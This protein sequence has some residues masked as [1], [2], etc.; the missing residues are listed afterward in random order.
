MNPKQLTTVGLLAAT[1]ALLAPALAQP[2]PAK[3]PNIVL[4]L[5]DD[6][7]W[8]DTSVA[9]WTQAT[10]LNQRFHTPSMQR[11]AAQGEVFTNAYACAICSPSHVSLMTGWNAARHRVTN[12]T[13]RKGEQTDPQRPN[14]Q[15]APWNVNGL[16][17]SP[18]TPRAAFA[19]TLPEELHGA[20]YRTI[21]VGKAHWGAF[22]TPGADPKNLGF[23]VNIGGSGTGQPGSYFGQ[24]NYS[25]GGTHDVPGLEKYHGTDT[26]LS[27]A[28][29]LKPMR[30]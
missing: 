27:E 7:G 24:K 14:L 17:N 19:P 18:D 15:S 26:F 6:M 3:N 23:D 9:F 20:G 11:L 10:P 21:H 4:F 2:A 29:T 30:R 25:D 28:L 22:D 13:F 1:A 5:V 12:W 8:Q 16:S